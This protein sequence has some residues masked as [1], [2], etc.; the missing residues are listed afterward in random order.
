MARTMREVALGEGVRTPKSWVTET[1]SLNLAR[2][3]SMKQATILTRKNAL[4]VAIMALIT[5]LITFVLMA[6]S[7]LTGGYSSPEA[8]E[9]SGSITVPIAIHLSTVIPAVL[10]GPIVLLRRKGDATHRLLG[11]IWAGLMLTTAIASA[12]IR[13]PGG[14][15]L[16]TGYSP[17]HIFTFWTLICIPL[18][19]WQVRKGKV[20]VHRQMM[21]GL[22]VG[23]LVA[24]AFS[25]IPGRIMGNL[26]F[27]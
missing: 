3:N 27:G 23:L 20:E 19:V 8:M 14:G 4:S 5:A 21:G 17:I 6:L 10:L 24:G 26:V 7:A 12:F 15:I 11:R 25:F 22:Y 2:A 18:A 1:I 16:G 13:A 9:R